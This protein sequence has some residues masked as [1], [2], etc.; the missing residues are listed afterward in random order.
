MPSQS[1]LTYQLSFSFQSLSTSYHTA[2]CYITTRLLFK[3]NLS[4]ILPISMSTSQSSPPAGIL[5]VVIPHHM[6]WDKAEPQPD[7]AIAHGCSLN[8]KNNGLALYIC[9][10]AIFSITVQ[11]YTIY[12]EYIMF[13]TFLYFN[14]K[15]EFRIKMNQYSEDMDWKLCQNDAC[16]SSLKILVFI[17]HL[18]YFF[19]I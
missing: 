2:L 18:I 5:N 17:Y 12:P 11:Q 14:V 4:Q 19:S 9:C 8:S 16:M 15:F 6:H 10:P 7:S 1:W 13:R 3:L